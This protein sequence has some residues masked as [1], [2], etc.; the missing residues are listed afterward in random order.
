MVTPVGANFHT[1][2]LVAYSDETK[3]KILL[4]TFPAFIGDLVLHDQMI[5]IYARR[6]TT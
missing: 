3:R 4:A 6:L 2:P 5:G 1:E